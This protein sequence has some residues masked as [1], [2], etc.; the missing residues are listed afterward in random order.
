MINNKTIT[1]FT[2]VWGNQVDIGNKV[3]NHC[4]NIFPFF[5][6]ILIYNKIN[7]LLDFNTFM[8]EKIND[9]IETDYVLIVQPDGF[10]INPSKWDNKFLS[11]DYIGAPW[12]W[13][14]LCGN[15]GFSLRSKKFLQL[16]SKLIYNKYHHEYALCPEDYFLCINN[17]NYFINNDCLFSSIKDG[18]D[19]SFEL[20]IKE[21]PEHTIAD[22]FG[23][24]GKFHLNFN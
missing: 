3:V 4:A 10:I 1:L 20:P 5:D 8:V 19:F 18:L 17:R 15:G 23:F 24:H 12:P 13:H 7:N 2:I 22:S 16:S 11:Y 6:K 14:A 21:Y 9:H